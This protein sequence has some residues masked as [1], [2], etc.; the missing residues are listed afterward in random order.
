MTV[1]PKGRI[2]EAGA[3]RPSQLSVRS[4]ARRFK[5]MDSCTCSKSE[6]DLFSVPPT[7]ISMEKGRWL[8]C[9]PHNSVSDNNF[10]E[11]DFS[12]DE[13][14][15]D[16]G[17]TFLYIKAKVTKKNKTNIDANAKVAL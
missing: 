17:R 13:E 8:E 11:F 10:L 15:L 3:S 14:Y 16:L 1:Y 2:K 9:V 12:S 4:G 6:L 5:K 7:N